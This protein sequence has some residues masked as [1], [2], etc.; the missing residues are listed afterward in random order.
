MLLDL[1]GNRTPEEWDPPLNGF[2]LSSGRARYGGLSE[3]SLEL[4]DIMGAI[5]RA[6]QTFTFVSAGC[7]Y[8]RWLALAGQI[9]KWRGLKSTRLIG[10][11]ADPKRYAQALEHFQENALANGQEAGIEITIHNAAVGSRAGSIRWNPDGGF[12]Q[13]AGA[14]SLEIPQV[15]IGGT[16]NLLTMDIQGDELDVLKSM[17]LSCVGMAHIS[18]HSPEIHKAV[19]Q[20]FAQTEDWRLRYQVPK[21]APLGAGRAIDGIQSWQ[22]DCWD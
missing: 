1:F 13:R 11:E 6:G 10:Y 22:N 17:D 5:E 21:D 20:L 3:D 15:T 12:G 8:G 9:C 18:T 4:M 16:M 14:G 2:S 7:G 19:G